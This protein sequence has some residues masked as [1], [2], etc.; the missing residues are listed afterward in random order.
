MFYVTVQVE[1]D[2]SKQ[3][4]VPSRHCFLLSHLPLLKRGIGLRLQ[5]LR[6]HYF[7]INKPN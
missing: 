6:K 4:H 5:K 3:P 2:S 7:K 1:T